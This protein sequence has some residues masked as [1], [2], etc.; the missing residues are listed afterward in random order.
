MN[1]ICKLGFDSMENTTKSIGHVS[2][3]WHV[4][5]ISTWLY[6]SDRQKLSCVCYYV[7]MWYGLMSVNETK[8]FTIHVK[9]TE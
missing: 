8:C 5:K 4:T 6:L 3:D 2:F 9:A 1:K 7:T